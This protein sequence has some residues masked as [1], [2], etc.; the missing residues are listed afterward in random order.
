MTD[1][2]SSEEGEKEQLRLR[3]SGEKLDSSLILWA[4]ESQHTA[5]ITHLGIGVRYREMERKLQET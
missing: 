4:E 5:K 1:L 2:S 3:D